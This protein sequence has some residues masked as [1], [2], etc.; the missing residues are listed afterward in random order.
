[1]TKNSERE[2][3]QDT[4]LAH[5]GVLGMKWG[6]RKKQPSIGRERNKLIKKYQNEYIAKKALGKSTK[7]GRGTHQMDLS[8]TNYAIQKAGTD[9]RKKYGNKAVNDYNRKSRNRQLKAG[10]ALA[11]ASLALMGGSILSAAIKSGQFSTGKL[12]VNSLLKK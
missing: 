1:M 6:V 4:Y 9:L 12:V 2:R 7:I 8:V 11:T 5:Y 3:E 10:A